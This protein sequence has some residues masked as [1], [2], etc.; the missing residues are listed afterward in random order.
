VPTGHSEIKPEELSAPAKD[1]RE[2]KHGME[3]L[4]VDAHGIRDERIKLGGPAV[5]PDAR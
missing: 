5:M 4:A 2:I 3:P 1:R